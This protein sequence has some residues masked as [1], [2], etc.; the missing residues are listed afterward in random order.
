MSRLS[1]TRMAAA[2]QNRHLFS[3]EATTT[4]ETPL[5]IP[6]PSGTDKVY[7]P[8][9][10]KLV[11]DIAKL[12]LLEVADLNDC[13]KKTLKIESVPMAMSPGMFAA[14]AALA[15]AAGGEDEEE[16]K[17][18]K[19]SFN[20]KLT[21]FDEGKKVALIKEVKTI[22][23]GMNLVQAKKFVESVPQVLKTNIAKDEAEKIKKALEA[24]GATVEI[25]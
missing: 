16:P 20:V 10:Q 9:I 7:P 14:Q 8:K 15:K 3:T 18:I 24:L 4:S 1:W 19:S 23:E 21:K 17:T 5:D 6:P 12:N 13:L 2:T 22:V 25:E 11:D